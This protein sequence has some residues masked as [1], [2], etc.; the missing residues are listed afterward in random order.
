VRETAPYPAD[1]AKRCNLNRHSLTPP[2]TDRLDHNYFKLYV[3]KCNLFP[4]ERNMLL[5]ECEGLIFRQEIGKHARKNTTII[6][7]SLS[8]GVSLGWNY[9]PLISVRPA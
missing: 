6:S 3:T 5:R 8:R 4:V 1:N 7:V 2:S 9:L